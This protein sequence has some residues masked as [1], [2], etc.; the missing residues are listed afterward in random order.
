MAAKF[1]KN[2]ADAL[3]GRQVKAPEL[4]VTAVHQLNPD[5][6]FLDAGPIWLKTRKPFLSEDT[7]RRKGHHLN[8]LNKFFGAATLRQCANPDLIRE[9]QDHR[10]A[11]A[12]GDCINKEIQVL[13]EMLH[14]VGL[15][16]DVKDDYQ[17]LPQPRSQLGMSL[18]EDQEQ[19]FVA[20]ANSRDEYQVAY[21][22]AVLAAQTGMS[23]SEIFRLQLQDIDLQSSPPQLHIRKGKNNYRLRA[24]PLE[25]A[26]VKPL[27]L[28]LQRAKRQGSA[29]PQHYLIPFR[30]KPGEYDPS[31]PAKGC[32]SAWRTLTRSIGLRGLRIKDMRHHSIT[33]LVEEN[34]SPGVIRSVVGHSPS[35][36]ML[37]TY[38][39]PRLKA[40]RAAM[41]ILQDKVKLVVVDP[42]VS[43]QQETPATDG[44]QP[45]V[46][47]TLEKASAPATATWMLVGSWGMTRRGSC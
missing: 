7:Y 3:A 33:V 22:V 20:A 31:K 36:R 23:P 25:D 4:S 40:K 9:Y 26:A 44:S 32:R 6:R 43:L 12:G 46:P 15:W 41:A 27:R 35:S 2:L 1:L 30:K 10:R 19:K 21:W 17:P 18:S 16:K 34:V 42:P 14:R 39:H 8:Q 11:R 5:M 28:L 29:R 24:V 13:A 37:E 45:A 38:S 47:I